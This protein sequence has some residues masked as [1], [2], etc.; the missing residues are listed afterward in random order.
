MSEKTQT[1]LV[2][3]FQN[4]SLFACLVTL[5]L[6]ASVYIG[7]ATHTSSLKSIVP[8]LVAMNPAT[9]ACFAFAALSLLL[10]LRAPKN[11]FWHDV[12]IV[13]AV[14]VASLGFLKFMGAVTGVDVSFDHVVFTDQLNN[15]ATGFKNRMAP[16]T[17][18]NFFFVGSSLLLLYRGKAYKFAHY[19]ACTTFFIALLAVLGYAYHVSNL[20]GFS[21]FIP[22][23]LN[24]AS[25]FIVLSVGILFARPTK[26]LTALVSS[27]S[28]GGLAMRRLV[29]AVILVPSLVGYLRVVGQRHGLF[30]TELGLALV[31]VANIMLFMVIVAR[32]ALRLQRA[33]ELLRH[34]NRRLQLAKAKD[35]ALLESL[36]EGLVALDRFY[37]V[38]VLNSA[39]EQ[40]LGRQLHEV[41]GKEF[42]DD[43]LRLE[44]EGGNAVSLKDGKLGAAF[45]AGKK[46]VIDGTTSETYYYVRK[47]KTKFPVAI[48]VTP[49]VL[50][51]QPSGV[52]FVF[53][54]LSE[55]KEL[56][57]SKGEFISLASHQLKTPP[58]AIGWNAEL[59]LAH[60]AGPLN[61]EQ[62]V[63]VKEIND[64][65]QHMRDV[66]ESLLNASRLELGTFIINP[67]PTDFRVVTKDVLKELGRQIHDKKLHVIS[68]FEKEVKLIPADPGL[69]KIIIENLI[70]NAVKY[71]PAKGKITIAIG[72]DGLVNS[73]LPSIHIAVSDNGIGIPKDQQTQIFN[74][75]FRAE[76][77]KVN[78]DGTGFGMYL[79]KTIVEFS[80]GA[81]WFE[82]V[83]NKGTTFHVV[84]PYTG[85]KQHDGT[86]N[87]R[88]VI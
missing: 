58:G 9:A 7:Y 17:A 5:G 76:N 45:T 24:T 52:I 31:I 78:A 71:T 81:V 19:L 13:L 16:N 12:G 34:T 15:V 27:D 68:Q 75:M 47:D 64:S 77:A 22:M 82:S 10:L 23:A 42:G 8:G 63:L 46:V 88:N 87:L 25:G 43:L 18:L 59:L 86:S 60:D 33:D 85:M 21:R 32:S 62:T 74:K 79:L 66:V 38:T 67:K 14:A 1:H 50:N 40:M 39:A 48:T 44:D 61:P 80:N 28:A 3:L 65:A 37:K 36:G 57:R 54:D 26:G 41:L 73:R 56:D 55:E 51:G 6:S 83:E 35:D 53:R 30:S 84:L 4:F 72:D 70:S 20:T 11:S 49:I 29:P 2:K 69:A